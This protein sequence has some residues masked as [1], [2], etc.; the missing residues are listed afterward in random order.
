MSELKIKSP[1][2]KDRDTG[3][4]KIVAKV[5]L[6]GA[7]CS[8]IDLPGLTV[9][10]TA[11]GFTLSGVECATGMALDSS[12]TAGMTI[13][14]FGTVSAL[15][16]N[17]DYASCNPF[18]PGD[19]INVGGTISGTAGSRTVAYNLDLGD[20]GTALNL[21]SDTITA[22]TIELVLPVKNADF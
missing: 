20:A 12:R 13:L 18:Y 19:I 11:T 5:T 2:I 1:A 10:G 21:T 8:T 7:C 3:T 17:A 15:P 22:A 4:L 6:N 9:A 16:A 14:A